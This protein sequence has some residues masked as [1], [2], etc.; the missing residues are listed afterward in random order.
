MSLNTLPAELLD[1]I[2]SDLSSLPPSLAKVHRTPCTRLTASRSRDLKSLSRTSWR[3]LELVRPQLFAHACFNIKDVAG[4]LSFISRLNLGR[5][6]MSIVAKGMDSADNRED[7]FWWRQ[8]LNCLDPLRITVIAPPPFLAAM[9]ETPILEEHSW[10]FEVPFQILQLEQASRV[11]DPP[12][13]LT[14]QS[15]G[16]LDARAWSSLDFN[17]SSSLKAYHHYEY[18]LFQ[19]PSLF[20]MWGTVAARRTF[21]DTI[22]FLRSFMSLTSLRYTAVFPTYNHVQQVLDALEM[23]TNLRS[24]SIQLAPSPTDKTTELEQRGSMDPSD[25][26]ME[27]TTGYSLVAHAVKDLG[28]RASLVEFHT[29]DYDSEALR[30]ELSPV[31][32]DVLNNSGWVHDGHCAWTKTL[33]KVAEPAVPILAHTLLSHGPSAAESPGLEQNQSHT[34]TR[35]WNLLDDVRNGLQDNPAGVFRSGTVI[36]FSRLRD[37]QKEDCEDD[38]YIGQLPRHLL[39]THLRH[40]HSTNTPTKTYIIH[41]ITFNAFAPKRLLASLLNASHHP[42]LSRDEAISQLDSVEIFPVY[43]FQAAAGAINLISD[44]IGPTPSPSPSSPS[45]PTLIIIA[46]LDTLAEGVIRASN[47]VRGA[48]MLT[49]VLRTLTQLTRMH[50]SRFSVMLVNTSGL[51]TLTAQSTTPGRYTGSLAQ[52]AQGDGI[53]SAFRGHGGDVSLFPSLLMRTLDQGVDTHLLISSVGRVSVVE[54]IKNRVGGHVG[55]WCVLE[56]MR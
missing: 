5:Y 4:F 47:A 35:D 43:D 13:A 39:T 20:T 44:S 49:S 52:I 21:S 54:V 14:K 6:V 12:L 9:L 28:D 18:F 27:I 36:G 32:G 26:W 37:I 22:P 56:G 2:I 3:L 29:S 40:C 23:M 31:L 50:L 8:V 15:A 16:L 51:G 46:G 1:Q 45:H 34:V 41:P 55:R 42:T 25:P 7:P 19:I 48:A 30:S 10:A 11:C 33:T 38:E 53:Y 24:F 17:E